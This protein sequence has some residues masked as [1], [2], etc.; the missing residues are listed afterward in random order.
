MDH[1]WSN[2]AELFWCSCCE[3]KYFA[4]SEWLDE[5]QHHPALQALLLM[6]FRYG[7]L[8]GS[9]RMS[10]P[11]VVSHIA[12]FMCFLQN[13]GKSSYLGNFL[14]FRQ[15][16]ALPKK[17]APASATTASKPLHFI[18]WPATGTKD[19]LWNNPPPQKK[20]YWNAYLIPCPVQETLSHKQMKNDVCFNKEESYGTW[21]INGF[22]CE[23]S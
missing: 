19:C 9:Y 6:N 21:K 3:S 8:H 4:L 1:P 18:H 15:T 22:S 11:K 5:K 13:L 20:N 17:Y 23:F 2:P 12:F 7:G 10:S 14:A 16:L